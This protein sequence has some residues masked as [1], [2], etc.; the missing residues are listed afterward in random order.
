MERI[1]AR[2]EIY[3]LKIASAMLHQEVELAKRN[4]EQNYAAT[5]K[6]LLVSLDAR[7]G[8]RQGHSERVSRFSAFLAEKAGLASDKILTVEQA[9]LIHDIGYIGVDGDLQKRKGPLDAAG[10]QEIRKHP[11]I[12]AQIISSVPFLKEM[13]PVILHHHERY[14]G[15]G[16][17][18]GLKGEAIPF[19]AR[20]VAVADCVDSML[21]DRPYRAALHLN[22][23]R[24]ELTRASGKQF[25]PEIIRLTLSGGILE[26]Y[27][28]VFSY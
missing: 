16:Y 13:E 21:C 1:G 2:F 7:D 10:V 25:D 14:D 8:F 26:S 3:R 18:D 4:I 5:I 15:T 27:T 23:V 9:A 20:I 28:G 24:E 6:R 11:L 12:G 17:P 19:S 22:E